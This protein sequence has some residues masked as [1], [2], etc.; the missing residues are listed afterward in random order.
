MK[1]NKIHKR[2]KRKK[3]FGVDPNPVTDWRGLLQKTKCKDNSSNF[4]S[5]IVMGTKQE[6]GYKKEWDT[7][8]EMCVCVCVCVCVCL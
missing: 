1:F 7:E 3:K 6:N 8:S 4:T 5:F 2:R